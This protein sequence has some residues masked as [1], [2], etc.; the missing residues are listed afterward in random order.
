MSRTLLCQ[1]KVD[2][3]LATLAK[4][5]NVPGDLAELG[6]YRGGV[7]RMLAMSEPRRTVHLFDTFTGMPAASE[8]DGYKAG[9]FGD[10]SLMGVQEYL[11]DCPNIVFHPGVFPKTAIDGQFA[12][13][14]LDADLFASTLAGLQWFWP[15]LSVGGVIILD[16]YDWHLCRGVEL[17][18]SEFFSGRTDGIAV[19][20]AAHQLTIFKTGV[21]M[22]EE[23]PT[24]ELPPVVLPRLEATQKELDLQQISDLEQ[25][26]SSLRSECESAAKRP[27]GEHSPE[28]VEY[29]QR[30][31]RK[32]DVVREINAL[33][34]KHGIK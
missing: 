15:R 7:A 25:E 18:A 26:Y 22:S 29:R 31:D 32:G 12:A 30:I 33:K 11:A 16:D 3:L 24:P 20:S 8:C 27:P 4:V 21:Y 23:N 10:C 14:H 28:Y 19:L 9:D 2:A 34:R 13:V 17:A 6:V 1:P 5:S